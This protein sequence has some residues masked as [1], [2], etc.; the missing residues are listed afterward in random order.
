MNL[1]SGGRIKFPEDY[2]YME[3]LVFETPESEHLFETVMRLLKIQNCGFIC[4][5]TRITVSREIGE[6]PKIS[7]SNVKV[8]LSREEQSVSARL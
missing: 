4:F 6:I 8:R 2:S 5:T 3:T 1:H 7:E